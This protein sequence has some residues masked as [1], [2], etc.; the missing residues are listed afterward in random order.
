M[1]PGM[2]KGIWGHFTSTVPAPR[3]GTPLWLPWQALTR[4][5]VILWRLSGGR[6]G[7]RYDRAPL[8]VL[9]HSGAKSNEPRETPLV[10]LRDGDRIVLVA[11]MGGIPRNPAWYHNVRAHPD[12]EVEMPGERRPMTARVVTDEAERADLWRR[13]LEVWPAW[14]DYQARTTRRLPVVVLEPRAS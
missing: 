6:I 10:Y 14:E 2:V 8:C 7:G 11:S 1:M 12:V 3:P 5:N 9:H 4:A 13:L